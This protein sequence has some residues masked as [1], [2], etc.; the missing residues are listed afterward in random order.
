MKKHTRKAKSYHT[1]V[2]NVN[3]KGTQKNLNPAMLYSNL[4]LKGWNVDSAV[5]GCIGYGKLY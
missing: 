5:K 2:Y 4:V 3:A 1:V